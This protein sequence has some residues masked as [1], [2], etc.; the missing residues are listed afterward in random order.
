MT[1]KDLSKQ[2]ISLA[3]KKMVKIA[4]AESCTGGALASAIVSIAGS[5]EVLDCAFVTYSDESKIELLRV[6]RLFIKD[7]SAVSAPVTKDMAIGALKISPTASMALAVT[8]FA[9]PTGD[10]IG[11]VYI[12]LATKEYILCKEFHFSGDRSSVRESAVRAGLEM[13]IEELEKA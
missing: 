2:L 13:L 12:A 10:K 9:G 5:S 1:A 7:H 4:L 6:D 3:S 11:L 8:G